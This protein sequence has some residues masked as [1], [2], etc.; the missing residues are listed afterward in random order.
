MIETVRHQHPPISIQCKMTGSVQQVR[1]PIPCRVL[2]DH[3]QSIS[4]ELKDTLK[5]NAG[6]TVTDE[7]GSPRSFDRMVRR[8]HVPWETH[9]S[10]ERPV[11]CEDLENVWP[12]LSEYNH[13]AFGGHGQGKRFPQARHPSG[14][15]GRL[16][17][18]HH[19]PDTAAG[20]VG[21]VEAGRAFTGCYVSR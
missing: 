21:D 15:L 16:L 14:G 12:A 11:W 8:V 2:P 9:A 20:V 19:L 13:S 4:A 17:Y 7:K 6:P 5:T 3:G 18:V 10:K 1:G